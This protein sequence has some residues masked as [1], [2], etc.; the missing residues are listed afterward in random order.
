MNSPLAGTLAMLRGLVRRDWILLV[1]WLLGVL[2]F[3][4]SGAG[5]FD[6]AMHTPSARETMFAL[7]RNP[8]M[9]GLFGPSRTT[10][11]TT[12]IA[13]MFGQTMSL[14]TSLTCAIISIVYVTDRTRKDEEEGVTELL[15]ALPV[16]RFAQTT[17]VVIEQCALQLLITGTLALS[18]QLQNVPTMTVFADN[19][20]FAATIGAQGLL[21]GIVSLVFAQVFSTAG[22]ARGASF[23]LLG[24]LYVIRMVTDTVHVDAGWFNPLSWSYLSWAYADDD[25]LPVAM[26][27]LLSSLL[28][29]VAYLLE[30]NRDVSAGYLAP[31]AGRAHAS[32]LLRTLPGIVLRER[33]GLLIGSL[34]GM[35]VAGVMYGS[36][37]GQ[38]T[39]FLHTGSGIMKRLLAIPGYAA[40]ATSQY[41]V[42]IL[43]LGGVATACLGT[44]LFSSLVRQER[45]NR[46]ELLLATHLSRSTLY[47]THLLIALAAT[48]AAQLCFSFALWCTMWLSRTGDDSPFS[49]GTV[50]RSGLVYM[51]AVW[52]TM[53][54]LALFMGLAPRLAGLV[55][56]YLG[57]DFLM[58]YVAKVIDFP[59]WVNDLNVFHDTPALPVEAMR[60]SEVSTVTA[61][62]LV[63]LLIGLIRYRERDLISG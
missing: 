6:L 46:L 62:A 43:S 19:L 60:W 59:D 18:I 14:L 55:W 42:T 22:S 26:T 47:L 53:G 17:A 35:C 27:V 8:A 33:R 20:L 28:L 50:I 48:A 25:W 21:W 51:P 2:A 58:G 4:A 3:A 13:T 37:F 32:R 9:V 12:T 61:V 56:A 34:A 44:A 15:L 30:T 5:K 10:A 49:C 52:F 63:L 54:L 23:A 40:S 38:M 11:S 7:F 36:M 31:R 39:A 57:F 1:A 24:G 29:A 16:G 41:L 45:R